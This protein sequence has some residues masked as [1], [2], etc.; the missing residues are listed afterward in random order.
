MMKSNTP[1]QAFASPI[2]EA[3]C[4]ALSDGR[5]LVSV[6]VTMLLVGQYKADTPLLNVIPDEVKMYVN[7]FG[8]LVKLVLS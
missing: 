1:P 7:V 8:V 4:L 5:A 3:K 2:D 6:S